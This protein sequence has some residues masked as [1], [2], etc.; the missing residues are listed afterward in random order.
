MIKSKKGAKIMASPHCNGHG[1]KINK[2][3]QYENIFHFRDMRPN[4]QDSG[5]S[6]P[7]SQKNWL[8]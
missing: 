7:A 2:I 4:L 8:N 3:V 1:S 6:P 5:A